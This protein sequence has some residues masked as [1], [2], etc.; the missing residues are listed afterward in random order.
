[1]LALKSLFGVIVENDDDV[2]ALIIVILI[3]AVAVA[4]TIAI[5]LAFILTRR[6]VGFYSSD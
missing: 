2:F 3:V 6:L 5:A 4:I 1:M